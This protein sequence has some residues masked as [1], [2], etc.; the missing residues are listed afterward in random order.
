MGTEAQARHDG[1]FGTATAAAVRGFQTRRFLTVDGIVGPATLAELK[2]VPGKTERVGAKAAGA[3][4]V[5]AAGVSLAVVTVHPGDKLAVNPAPAKDGH[6]H[7]EGAGPDRDPDRDRAG[8]VA[9]VDHVPGPLHRH[10]PQGQVTCGC[11]TSCGPG[12]C[13]AATR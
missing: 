4:A 9:Y 2:G 6:A 3:G 12:P 11:A 7:R 8:P 1:V 5:M 13:P 10:G